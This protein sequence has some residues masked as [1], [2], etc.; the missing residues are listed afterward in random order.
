MRETF[1]ATNV[2][3]YS[4]SLSREHVYIR[5]TFARLFAHVPYHFI[6]P[7][8]SLAAYISLSRYRN[9]SLRCTSGESQSES[10]RSRA[11]IVFVL[12]VTTRFPRAVIAHEI[13]GRFN[14]RPLPPRRKGSTVK[15]AV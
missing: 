9:Y 1:E 11:K 4:L 10:T 12:V 15:R 13:S 7:R 8:P 5:K 2:R 3:T 6:I 14:H